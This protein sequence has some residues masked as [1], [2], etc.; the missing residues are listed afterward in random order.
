MDEIYLVLVGVIGYVLFVFFIRFFF[1][2]VRGI[3]R[4]GGLVGIG[5]RRISLIILISIG[6][7]GLFNG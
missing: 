5:F 1:C 6:V 7:L 2:G 4:L 3:M